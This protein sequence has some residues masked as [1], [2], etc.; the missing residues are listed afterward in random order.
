MTFGTS[1]KESNEFTFTQKQTNIDE[2]FQK[3]G[4]SV[5]CF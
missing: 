2:L 5:Q 4:K 1:C 3:G